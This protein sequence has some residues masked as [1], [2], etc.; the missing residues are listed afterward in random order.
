MTEEIPIVY[1]YSNEKGEKIYSEKYYVN[2]DFNE[3][4]YEEISVIINNQCD[5]GK[6]EERIFYH[7]FEPD[8]EKFLTNLEQFIKYVNKG[9]P[10]VM[11]SCSNYARSIIQQ[12]REEENRYILGKNFDEKESINEQNS[13]K[14]IINIDEDYFSSDDK[15]SNAEKIILQL[16]NNLNADLFTEEFI[17]HEGIKYLIS[18]AYE[19][20]GNIKVYAL[21]TLNKLLLFQSSIDYIKKRFELIEVLYEI[22]MRSDS[23]KCSLCI[24]DILIFIISHNKEKVT[25]FIDIS[26]NYAKKSNTKIYSQIIVLLT[27]NDNVNIKE[28]VLV[29]INC[30]LTFCDSVIYKK[31]LT[32]LKEAR[33]DESLEKNIKIKEKEFQE[34]LEVFQKKTGIIISGSNYELNLYKNQYDEMRKKFEESKTKNEKISKKKLIL[35]DILNEFM[36]FQNDV[37]FKKKEEILCYQMTPKG[38]YNENTEQSIKFDENGIL[39][40]SELLKN[41][42]SVLSQEI[43]EK[44][45][46]YYYYKKESQKFKGDTIILEDKQKE[47]T[48]DKNQAQKNNNE[49][50]LLEKEKEIEKEKEK[51][52][53]KEVN[54]ESKKEELEEKTEK[55]EKNQVQLLPPIPPP[56]SPPIGI[57]LS[58]GIP[59][60]P[61][62]I[63]GA[64]I[65]GFQSGP[66]PTKE[67]IKLKTKVKSLQ[68]TRII[69]DKN[70][71]TDLIWKSI[72]EPDIDQNEII[73]LFESK[74]KKQ[75]PKKK[76]PIITKKKFLDNKRA[77]EVEILKKKL[78]KIDII[79][80]ALLEM[81]EKS[82]SEDNIEAL[83]DIA[84][85]EEELATY[86]SMGTDGIWE[87]NEMFLIEL[88]EIPNYKEKLN[89]WCL[90][91]K[92]EYLLPRLEESFIYM[93]DACNEIKNDKHFKDLLFTILSL[94]N[95]LNSGTIN[96]KAVGF[97]LDF[98]PTLCGIKDNFGKSILSFICAQLNKD[99]PS[100]EDIKKQ[101]PKLEKAS[102]FS[103]KETKKKLDEISIKVNTVD[104][105]LKKLKQHDTFTTKATTSLERAKKMIKEYQKLEKENREYYHETILF[106]GYEE[107]DKD[108][109]KYYDDNE[110]FFKMLLNFFTE[111]DKYIPKTNVKRIED[112]QN[113]VIGQKVDP[114]LLH[115]SLMDEL[116]QNPPN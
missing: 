15:K 56:P 35:Q 60:P 104:E 58:P 112:H 22:L 55:E 49:L 80:T 21:E 46:K 25:L 79:S 95:F 4:N 101:F 99:D 32:Q 42:K 96:G 68:W 54:F 12:L 67:K 39:D 45:E 43:I 71:S 2:L 16:E 14:I 116:K 105:L 41:N 59:P 61:T 5:F 76:K 36:V 83:L 91:L 82:L 20:T 98:L 1:E 50:G 107:K 33:I 106:F 47:E 57:P 100:F 102:R 113:R 84:I 90:I 103:M 69:L 44:I 8:E 29:F 93:K 6:K 40:F 62:G 34:Q 87:N 9:K 28:K 88:N 78:P 110:S 72:T 26:E 17:S 24:L 65:F 38:R 115:Q 37:N 13:K 52:I 77:Q 75:A 53:V 74:N 11:K 10:V 97:Y 109:N 86:K 108:N 48:A 63:P 31:V 7:M 92:Y 27:N 89:I 114:K 23:K 18:F 3:L 111:V 19:A 30:L 81:D 70:D 51:E 94:G 64:P 66:Q 73:S 85:K